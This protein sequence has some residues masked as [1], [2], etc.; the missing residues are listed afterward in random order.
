MDFTRVIQAFHDCGYDGSFCTEIYQIPD[1]ETAAQ[2]S[3]AH[4]API[5]AS[6]YGRPMGEQQPQKD[7]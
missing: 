7:S 6:I 4:L 3:I 1:M 2:R 5:F